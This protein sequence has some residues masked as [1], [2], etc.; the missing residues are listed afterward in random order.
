MAAGRVLNLVC[1]GQ[2]VATTCMALPSLC[3]T[4]GCRYADSGFDVLR[5][6]QSVSRSVLSASICRN[7]YGTGWKQFVCQSEHYLFS[8]W[9]L[10]FREVDL[11]C[12]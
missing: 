1:E 4:P 2:R 6:I 3:G 10:A 5:F 7:L 8:P 12:Q 9:A 11:D